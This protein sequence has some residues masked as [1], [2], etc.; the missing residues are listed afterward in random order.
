[1]DNMDNK[2]LDPQAGLCAQIRPVATVTQAMPMTVT[3]GLSKLY[4]WERNSAKSV[5]SNVCKRLNG[6]RWLSAMLLCVM[7]LRVRMP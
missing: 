2:R 7:V 1:M 4:G 5:V 3:K 6:S